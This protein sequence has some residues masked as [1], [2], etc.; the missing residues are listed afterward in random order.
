MDLFLRSQYVASLPYTE[1]VCAVTAPA[2][3]LLGLVLLAQWH[4]TSLCNHAWTYHGA[5]IAS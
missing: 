3:L 4:N 1:V 5:S 2:H